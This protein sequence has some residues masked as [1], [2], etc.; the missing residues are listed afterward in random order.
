MTNHYDRK[1]AASA[2]QRGF[3]DHLIEL[4]RTT[5]QLLMLFA[6]AVG[7]LGCLV[8]CVWVD[9]V[10]PS[11]VQNLLVLAGVTLI[12]AHLF[13]RFRGFYHSIVRYLGMDLLMAGGPCR[14]YIY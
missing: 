1:D 4:P 14:S 7:F 10:N 3:R 2:A 11:T 5:K 13:A 6:D 9:L 8:L 12:V